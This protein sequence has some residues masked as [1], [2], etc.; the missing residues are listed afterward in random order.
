MTAQMDSWI[1]RQSL[2]FGDRVRLEQ[3]HFVEE[4][5]TWLSTRDSFSS[6]PPCDKPSGNRQRDG[7]QNSTTDRRR[8][9]TSSIHLSLMTCEAAICVVIATPPTTNVGNMRTIENTAFAMPADAL[10]SPFVIC[11]GRIPV[12]ITLYFRTSSIIFGS[13]FV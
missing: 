4:P 7:P 10:S 1:V 6:L 9:P 3:A 8:V 13:L 11:G 2:M 12:A 5:A